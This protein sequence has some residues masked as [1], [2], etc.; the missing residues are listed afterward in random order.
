MMQWSGQ[1]IGLALGGGGARGFAHIGVLK[2]LEDEGIPIDIIAGT[3]M[4]AIIGAAYACG[5]SPS[6]LREK[7]DS[8]ISSPEFIE[9]PFMA[10]SES[11]ASNTNKWSDRIKRFLKGRFYMART[12]FKPGFLTAD[13]FQTMINYFVPD[14]TMEETKIPF[15][16]IATDLLTGDKIIFSEGSLRKAVLASCAVPGAVEPIKDGK[17]LLADGGVV[18]LVPVHAA[19]DGGADIVIAVVVDIDIRLWND[20]DTAKGIFNRAGEITMQRL[21]NYE[22]KDADVI[23]RPD[24]GKLHWTDFSRID[25]LEMEGERSAR[26][27]VGKIDR[28]LPFYLRWSKKVRKLFARSKSVTR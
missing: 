13:E 14:V 4:G 11:P 3:S 27:A 1:R 12:M 5:I 19:R 23:I 10:I 21:L 16:A 20:F 2:A 7:V 6:V 26:K 25:Y 17:Y 22:L 9:S 28:A 24:V 18:S 15:R 8:Y